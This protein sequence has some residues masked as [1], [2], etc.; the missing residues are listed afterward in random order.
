VTACR[1]QPPGGLSGKRVLLG[2]LTRL[3]RNLIAAD[4]VDIVRARLVRLAEPQ[5]TNVQVNGLNAG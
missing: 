1:M 2:G 5:P 3:R 4:S